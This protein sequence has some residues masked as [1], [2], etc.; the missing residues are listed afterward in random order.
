MAKAAG[1]VTFSPQLTQKLAETL[2]SPQRLDQLS[3]R[4]ALYAR[5]AISATDYWG[6][7]KTVSERCVDRG[8]KTN[9]SRVLLSVIARVKTQEYSRLVLMYSGSVDSEDFDR[10]RPVLYCIQVL[11]PVFGRE[12]FSLVA[13]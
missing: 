4:T 6:T 5:G 3:K 1:G 10:M 7:L 13:G 11:I 2:G 8:P 12:L 9:V